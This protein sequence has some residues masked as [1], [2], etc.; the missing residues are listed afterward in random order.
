MGDSDQLT[1]SQ[2]VAHF[3]LPSTRFVRP[4]CDGEWIMCTTV[5][6]PVRSKFFMYVFLSALPSSLGAGAKWTSEEIGGRNV[7]GQFF[8]T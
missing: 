4:C 8:H 1:N 2:Q 5:C 6:P 3:P 7:V